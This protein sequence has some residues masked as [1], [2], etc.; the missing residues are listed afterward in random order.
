MASIMTPGSKANPRMDD[1]GATRGPVRAPRG[2][3][4][5]CRS[6]QAEAAL[7]MLMNNLDPE[8]AEAPEQL[9]VY[10]GRGK[11]ARDWASFDAIVATLK[12]LAPDETLLVQSGKPVG[13]VRTF[14]DAPRAPS[15]RRRRGSSSPRRPRGRGCS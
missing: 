13:V 7:R 3:A 11:A 8:V 15:R 1:S 10:G 6:W 4:L 5:S 9:V 14:E 12:R 2:T